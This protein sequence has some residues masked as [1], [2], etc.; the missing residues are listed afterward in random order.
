MS[1]GYSLVSGGS[2]VIIAIAI[3]LFESWLVAGVLVVCSVVQVSA[4]L[5]EIRFGAVGPLRRPWVA[6]LK[7]LGAA[8]WC[9]LTALFLALS[10]FGT[11]ATHGVQGVGIPCNDDLPGI[12]LN[13]E[14]SDLPGLAV[15]TLLVFGQALGAVVLLT[16]GR[17]RLPNKPLQSASSA[18]DVG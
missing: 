8:V 12:C 6:V 11:I 7:R 13:S 1:A 3:G 2:V 14:Y 10:A 15:M 9:A 17:G 4:L 16:S 5:S 18:A